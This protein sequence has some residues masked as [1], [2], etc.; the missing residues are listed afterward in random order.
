M[1]RFTSDGAAVGD[2]VIRGIVDWR[3]EPEAPGLIPLASTCK[4]RQSSNDQSTT[5]QEGSAK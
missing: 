2:R 3:I 1:K 5:N 4:A